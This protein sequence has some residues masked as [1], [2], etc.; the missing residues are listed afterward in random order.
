MDRPV[1]PDWNGLRA[2]MEDVQKAVGGIGDA[3][4]K[5]LR[6]SGTAWSEDRTIKAVVGPRGHLVEL[7]I[8]PRVYRKP[9]SKQLAADILATVRRA[10][11]QATAQA[12]EIVAEMMPR[13]LRLKQFG[14]REFDR[15]IGSHDADVRIKGDDDGQ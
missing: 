15:L 5:M 10:V 6:V 14:G 4:E 13:D 9:N 11:E 3:Q 7:E 1:G 12:Q 2:M 8:D